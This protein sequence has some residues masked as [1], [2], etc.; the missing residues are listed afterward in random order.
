M[1]DL[2]KLSK[3]MSSGY[4]K[5]NGTKVQVQGGVIT[6]ESIDAAM[7]SIK[8]GDDLVEPTYTFKSQ[9]G[10]VEAYVVNENLVVVDSYYRDVDGR[11]SFMDPRRVSYVAPGSMIETWLNNQLSQH[12]LK[13]TMEH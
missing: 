2:D 5:W 1:N 7:R 3:A 8:F 10:R 6:L 9:N 13:M 11:W 4:E 12:I